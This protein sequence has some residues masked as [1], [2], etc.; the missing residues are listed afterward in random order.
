[1]KPYLVISKE[2]LCGDWHLPWRASARGN[3]DRSHARFLAAERL[4][5]TGA[6]SILHLTCQVIAVAAEV[7]KQLAVFDGQDA[8]HRTVEEVAVVRDDQHRADEL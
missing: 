5:M 2:P 6:G 4:E 3:P 8:I 7:I 1:M